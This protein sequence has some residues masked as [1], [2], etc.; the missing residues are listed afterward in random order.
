MIQD[1]RKERRATREEVNAALAKLQTA[2]ANLVK[3]VDP[4]PEPNPEPKPEPKPESD[5]KP[6]TKPDTEPDSRQRCSG[7]RCY[8][9][10]QKR[11][12]QGDKICSKGWYGNTC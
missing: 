12:L 11:Y 5:T 7:K 3:G 9:Q 6:D 1:I 2:R 4:K 8:D 10:V